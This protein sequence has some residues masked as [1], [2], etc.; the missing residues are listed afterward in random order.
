MPNMVSSMVGQSLVV[1]RS[2]L[3]AVGIKAFEIFENTGKMFV[4]LKCYRSASCKKLLKP[5]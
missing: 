2:K 5:F 1:V 4:T 3:F